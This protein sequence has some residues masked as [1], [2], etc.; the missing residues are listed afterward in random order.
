MDCQPNDR[1]SQ[2]I[3]GFLDHTKLT[4]ILL[5]YERKMYLWIKCCLISIVERVKGVQD[6][7]GR[8]VKY[9]WQRGSGVASKFLLLL[10][11]RRN[12]LSLVSTVTYTKG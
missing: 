2:T 6:A 5:E 3:G 1:C 7:P 10:Q 11:G 4:T 8:G 12:V 9:Q